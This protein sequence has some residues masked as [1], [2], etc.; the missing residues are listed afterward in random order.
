MCQINLVNLGPVN[1]SEKHRKFR[2]ESWQNY[3]V[4]EVSLSKCEPPLR[5][6]SELTFGVTLKAVHCPWTCILY[7][8]LPLSLP[9]YTSLHLFDNPFRD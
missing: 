6:L 2:D 3:Q 8:S 5:R 4:S 9:L 7:P 1:V